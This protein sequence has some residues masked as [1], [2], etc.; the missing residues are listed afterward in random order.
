MDAKAEVRENKH[1]IPVIDRMMDILA[2]L[3][4]MPPG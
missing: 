2:E 3:E 1:T 4:R